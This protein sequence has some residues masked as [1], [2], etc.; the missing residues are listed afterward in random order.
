MNAGTILQ[1]LHQGAMQSREQLLAAAAQA[2]RLLLESPD[3]MA[4][5]PEVLQLLGQAADVDRT[6]L[7]LADIGPDGERW[8]EIKA[9]WNA[10][11]ITASEG[12]DA[13]SDWNVNR[14]A[15]CFCTE[16]S[17]GRSVY[18]CGSAAGY[19]TS[20]ASEEAKSSIIV[21]FLVDGEYGGVVGFDTFRNE[22]HYDGAVVSAL[23]IAASVIGAALQRD[24]LLETMRREREAAAEQRVAELARANAALR[25]NLER[26]ASTPTD[27]FNHLLVQT[28]RHAGAETATAITAGYDSDTWRVACHVRDGKTCDAEFAA[29]M[30]APTSSFMREMLALRKALHLPLDGVTTVPEWPEFIAAHV[31]A[32]HRSLYVLPLLFGE[33]NIGVV[34]LGFARHEPLRLEVAELLEALGQQATLAM[35]MKRLFHTAHQSAVLAERNRIGREIH[36]GLA[37]AFTGILMQLNAAEEQLEESPLAGVMNRVRDIAREGLHEARRSVLALR[38]DEQPRPGG[39]ALALRQLA[40]RATVVGRIASSFHGGGATGLPP[41][42][43][44]ALLRIAQEAVINAA[45]HG[46]P[47]NIEIHLNSSDAEVLLSI[48]DDGRG[49]HKMPELYARQGFGLNNMRERAEDL[50]GQWQIESEPG[51]GTRVTVRIPRA[52]RRA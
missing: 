42:H 26:L 27:F 52:P 1:R 7:A 20:I 22:R 40:E 3:A 25:S 39:L 21:P 8:L 46:E 48:H 32:G 11:G 2:S 13:G 41:E 38:P 30:P 35:A 6:T 16:L 23:E 50:G 33:Q 19:E 4:R 37:Q 51:A 10:P 9:Q 15:D 5:M 18:L 45:R 34:A 43:E 49:M 14:R 24:R 29:S 31:D 36:D 44:H 12:R 17:A 47:R 28:V